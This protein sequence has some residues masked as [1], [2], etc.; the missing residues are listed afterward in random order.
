MGAVV[1]GAMSYGSGTRSVVANA[2]VV[3]GGAYDGVFSTASSITL[4]ANGSASTYLN[5]HILSIQYYN[6]KL[7]DAKLQALT[8]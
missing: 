2:G 7:S 4:G 6:T 8:A 3:S 1:K 5:G